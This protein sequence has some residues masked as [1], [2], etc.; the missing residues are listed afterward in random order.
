M[1]GECA[2]LVEEDGGAVAE[3]HRP[4]HHEARPSSAGLARGRRRRRYAGIAQQQDEIGERAD[5]AVEF[6]REG[7]GETGGRRRA[8]APA[9]RSP[10]APRDFAEQSWPRDAASPC[11]PKP[12]PAAGRR[13]VAALRPMAALLHWAWARARLPP[14]G[15]VRRTRRAPCAA[16]RLHL[17][18][19]GVRDQSAA[20]RVGAARACSAAL[21]ACIFACASPTLGRLVGSSFAMRLRMSFALDAFDASIERM[22]AAVRV[23]QDEVAT[24]A[25]GEDPFRLRDGGGERSAPSSCSAKGSDPRFAFAWPIAPHVR[26]RAAAARR[27]TLGLLPA[28]PR[29]RELG[30]L[31]LLAGVMR[32]RRRLPRSASAAAGRGAGASA[33]IALVLAGS[34]HCGRRR[35]GSGLA[36]ARRRHV[37][38]LL[39][40]DRAQRAHDH[41]LVQHAGHQRDGRRPIVL[42]RRP[43]APGSA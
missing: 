43:S 3:T 1:R 13:R 22:R 24:I 19:A 15:V 7:G 18:L 5:F 28:S 35:L 29:R 10:P 25:S 37:L 17:R 33:S 9:S 40:I 14:G 2:D 36:S 12:C 21:A 20:Q 26:S 8:G 27:S 42:L 34:R 41:H 30:A 39:E 32:E 16:P 4:E 11:R 23:D 6:G 38:G 31:R